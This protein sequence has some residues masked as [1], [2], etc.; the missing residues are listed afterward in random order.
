MSG[1][2]AGTSSSQEKAEAVRSEDMAST[3]STSS[4]VSADGG[5][6]GSEPGPRKASIL[7]LDEVQMADDAK[8]EGNKLYVQKDYA[9]ALEC[10]ARALELIPVHEDTIQNRATYH[11]NRAICFLQQ[12]EY[13]DAVKES[14]LALELNPNYVKA[15]LRRAQAHEK[16]DQLEESL[17]DL[18]KVVELDPSDKQ[19]K[20]AVRRLEPAVMAKREKMKEEMLGKLKDLGNS[21]LGHFGMSLD[22]FKAVQDPKTGGY[23]V[24]FQ[25]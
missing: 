9:G 17:Q 15:L 8:A 7:D 1:S 18:K 16:L 12:A 13:V 11:A 21:L 2:A 6:F 24:N 20:E 14:T 4:P 5:D 3:T 22:N 10:Y 23:S 25:R 19:A